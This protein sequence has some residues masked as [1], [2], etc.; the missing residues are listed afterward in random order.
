MTD[1]RP[2]SGNEAS[3]PPCQLLI[4]TGK[5]G[6]GKTAVTTALVNLGSGLL[7]VVTGLVVF[8]RDGKMLTY[9]VLV[10]VMGTLAWWNRR[11][12]GR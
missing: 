2:P 4:V 12:S 1:T 9:T 5:G 3:I 11:P 10:V 6:V 8:G 7:V